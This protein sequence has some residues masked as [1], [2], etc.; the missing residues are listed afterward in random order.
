MTAAVYDQDTFRGRD[1]DV[2]LNVDT[3]NGGGIL[4][5]DW[6][7]AVDVNFR[8]RFL[9]QETAGG[10]KNNQTFTLFYNHEGAG[11]TEMVA[12]GVLSPAATSQYANGDTTSQLIGGGS[13]LAGDSLGGVDN[14]EDTGFM[15]FAA[16]EEGELEFCLTIDSAQVA[17]TD[18]ILVRVYT[19]AGVALAAYTDTPTI[20][21]SE[22]GPAGPVADNNI[23]LMQAVMRASNF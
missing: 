5:A 7:Q 14:G 22:S 19:S 17:D 10:S 15:D 2:G 11:Y 13:Y 16:N 1:D 12:G 20:T 9:V 18:T 4:G 3:W 6:T 21:V 23:F 8:V